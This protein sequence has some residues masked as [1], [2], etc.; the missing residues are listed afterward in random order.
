MGQNYFSILIFVWS[1]LRILNFF[2][3]GHLR[4]KYILKHYR[5]NF[6]NATGSTLGSQLIDHSNTIVILCI[7]IAKGCIA[8]KTGN[9]RLKIKSFTSLGWPTDDTKTKQ[10]LQPKG[11]VLRLSSFY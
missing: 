5:Q 4:I 2:S 10:E 6:Q 1:K 7:L 3:T 9:N 11:R 8:V